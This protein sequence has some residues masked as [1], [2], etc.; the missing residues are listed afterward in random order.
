[1]RS[2]CDVPEVGHLELAHDYTY[3]AALIDLRDLHLNTRDSLH[4]AS[5]ARSAVGARQSLLPPPPQPPG[6]TPIH[7]RA[8]RPE[9]HLGSPPA[10]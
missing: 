6:R 2:G 7:R 9:V 10:R 8:V 3:E 4:M 5:T 1:M